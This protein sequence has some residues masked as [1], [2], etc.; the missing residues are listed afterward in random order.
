MPS[1]G[2]VAELFTNTRLVNL[3]PSLDFSHMCVLI[4][5]VWYQI[6]STLR[7]L[8]AIFLSHAV[9]F[10]LSRHSCLQMRLSK[11]KKNRVWALI[12]F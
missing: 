6:F 4:V 8:D 11:R 7:S 9:F 1:N 5:L 2:F 10:I 12:F 3:S